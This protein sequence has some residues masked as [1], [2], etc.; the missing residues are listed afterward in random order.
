MLL[1]VII[2]VSSAAQLQPGLGITFGVKFYHLQPVGGDEGHK[3][4]EMLLG[5]GVGDGDKMFIFH[6][7][8]NDTVIIIDIFCFQSGQGD[9]AATDHRVA[10]A[11]DCVSADR[12]DMEFAT[13]H[14]GRNIFVGD[15]FAVHQFDDGDTEGLCQRLQ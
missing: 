6:L 9:T 5:H 3:R 12:T 7:F 1:A 4:Y 15:L 2:E 14:I 13:Q 11:G 8:Y 10:G